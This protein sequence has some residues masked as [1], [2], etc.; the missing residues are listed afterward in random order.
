MCALYLTVWAQ[1]LL[2]N[3][4]KDENCEGA[5]G[6]NVVGF[7]TL[8]MISNCIQLLTLAGLLY[9]LGHIMYIIHIM[10]IIHVF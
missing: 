2:L 4:Q 3:L 10:L 6:T 1:F 5:L 8:N 9:L 7:L